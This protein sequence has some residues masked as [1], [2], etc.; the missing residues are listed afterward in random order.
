[1]VTG[2]PAKIMAVDMNNRRFFLQYPSGVH[3]IFVTN[4]PQDLSTGDTVFLSETGILKAPDDI[5][6]EKDSVG[7]VRR[8]LP[9]GKLLVE[10]SIGLETVSNLD[11]NPLG[12]TAGNTV[13]YRD[14]TG[15][16]ALLSDTPIGIRDFDSNEQ[17]PAS[18]FRVDMS[19]SGLCFADFGGYRE[20]V[21]RA[22]EII[23][24]QLNHKNHLDNIG[25][26]PIKG[27][28]FT[29]PPGTGKTLLARIIAAQS[30]AEF[31]LVSGPSIVSKW[32]GDSENT[33]RQIFSAAASADRAII[34]FDEID[35]L[36]ENR[37]GDTHEASKRLVAQL[38]TLMD[39]FDES[40]GNI[41]VIA[42]TNRID[43][44][45]VA[46]RR[47]GRFDWEITF[48]MP[49]ADDR[50]EILQASMRGLA[51]DG[52]LP[53]EEIASMTEGWSA[54]RISS[55]WTESALLAAADSRD[56]ICDEDLVLAFSQIKS[57]TVAER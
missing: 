48:G 47:P 43:D 6:P 2:H 27:V 15:V 13:A 14:N 31:F 20:V 37:T 49:T 29:G 19:T 57:R 3:T 1:M 35:S 23:N 8:M 42:A 7:V 12:V 34:F 45:D 41:I 53:I 40:S 28:L 50:L 51:I 52:E 55:L 33:L 32:V 11:D 4:E 44:I 10:R 36:A 5:W 21:D 25:A 18:P 46:L 56:S 22:N 38:L 24:T 9:G 16:K 17:D 30:N 39:G 26:R 54:A